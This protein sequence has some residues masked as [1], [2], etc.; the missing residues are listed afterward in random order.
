MNLKRS[1]E[2]NENHWRYINGTKVFHQYFSDSGRWLEKGSEIEA[3]A[4][5]PKESNRLSGSRLSTIEEIARIASESTDRLTI[6]IQNC[7]RKIDCHNGFLQTESKNVYWDIVYNGTLACSRVPA[8]SGL[9]TDLLEALL[10]EISAKKKQIDEKSQRP[11]RLPEKIDVVS[12]SSE[13]MGALLHELVG[14]RLEEDRHDRFIE[15]DGKTSF[16]VYD[17]PGTVSEYGHTPFDDKGTVGK[18]VKILDGETGEQKFLGVNTGNL[19]AIDYRWHPI[20]RQR[21]LEIIPLVINDSGYSRRNKV[22]HIDVFRHGAALGEIAILDSEEQYYSHNGVS[23]RAPKVRVT[24]NTSA[25]KHIQFTGTGEWTHPA[26]GCH[27]LQQ[28][29]LPISQLSHPGFIPS[30]FVELRYLS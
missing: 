6:K 28:R 13:A 30:R 8:T 29:G 27:K 24:V 22:L 26:G 16:S 7:Y 15:L 21:C 25:L 4:T 17:S 2:I 3:I 5:N 1:T 10:H 18:R 23:Y 14:H 20:P 11:F 9:N 19:R 12:L